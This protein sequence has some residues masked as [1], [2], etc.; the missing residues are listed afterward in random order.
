MHR[1]RAHGEHP[2]AQPPPPTEVEPVPGQGQ[3][4]EG[5][6]H[7]EGVG[8]EQHA[9]GD[10]RLPGRGHREDRP[11]HRAGAEPGQSVDRAEQH[12]REQ[13]RPG[14]GP[15]GREVLQASREGDAQPAAQDHQDPHRH[16]EPAG[17]GHQQLAVAVEEAGRRGGP[18]PQRHQRDEQAEVEGGRAHELGG[19]RGEGVGEEGRQQQGAARG[20][21]AE[22]PR[23]DSRE[24]PD[25]HHRPASASARASSTT[26]TKTSVGWAP[27]TGRPLMRK[28]GVPVTPMD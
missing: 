15:S 8:G 7:P 17:R 14:A 10:G 25:F 24:Q 18:H 11:Q 22:H 1:Q 20:E 19:R 6:R 4:E 9:A 3:Q 27:M 21:Q 13:A 23:D 26:W 28:A 16:H 5:Q 2:A 12:R